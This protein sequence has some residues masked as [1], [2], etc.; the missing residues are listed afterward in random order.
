MV[1]NVVGEKFRPLKARALA[2]A[3]RDF[4]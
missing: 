3:S 1:M 4:H 2:Y